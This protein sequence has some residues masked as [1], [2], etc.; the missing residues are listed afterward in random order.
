MCRTQTTYKTY[1]TKNFMVGLRLD[2]A[3]GFFEHNEHGDEYGGGLWFEK[4]ELVDYD[5][6]YSLPNEVVDMLKERGI[7]VALI[8]A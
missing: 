5:G 8:E 2:G 3:Y 7:N 4:G 1:N 6:V